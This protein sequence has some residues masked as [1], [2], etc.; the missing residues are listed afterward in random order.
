MRI[1]IA[2]DEISS[3]RVLEATLLTWDYEVVAVDDGTKAWEVL[4][5]EDRPQ[6]AVLDIMMPG[7]TGLDLCRK[8]RKLGP[9]SPLYIIL[10][11]AR[12]D[13]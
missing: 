4:Q 5:C 9:A 13:K 3:R 7:L 10:L 6:L 2:E 11:T 12:R 1:L 8:V